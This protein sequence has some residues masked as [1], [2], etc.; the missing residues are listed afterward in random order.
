MKNYVQKTPDDKKSSK[1][2]YIYTYDE[3][4]D[5]ANRYEEA[6]KPIL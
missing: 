4:M 5:I 3:L 2:S 6:A 1:K